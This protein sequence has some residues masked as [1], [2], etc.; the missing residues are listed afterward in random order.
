MAVTDRFVPAAPHPHP[1][2]SDHA[3]S[4]DEAA[5]RWE[6]VRVPPGRAADPPGCDISALVGK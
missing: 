5:V 6:D 2:A 1:D 3:G 4:V